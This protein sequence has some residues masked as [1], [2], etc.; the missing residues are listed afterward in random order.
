MRSDKS[1]RDF[2]KS[3]TLVRVLPVVII[4]VLLLVVGIGSGREEDAPAETAEVKSE[5][6]ELSEL[7]SAVN[8]VGRCRTMIT[9]SD[10]GQVYAV[11]VLCDGA[12]SA[13]VRARVVD[14]VCSL[15]GIG[16]NRIAILPYSQR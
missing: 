3:G 11:A 8:G 14:L 12:E 1:F 5:A 15:Y 7:C 13:L 16:S 2:I 9:Y 6:E 4:G 10:G